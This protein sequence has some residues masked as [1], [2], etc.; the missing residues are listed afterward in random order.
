MTA[1]I[2]VVPV[3]LV[4]EL[5]SERPHLLVE[6]CG[7]GLVVHECDGA[8]LGDSEHQQARHRCRSGTERA[9][10]QV[11]VRDGEHAGLGDL[12]ENV[13]G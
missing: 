6:C 5:G 9:T 12:A 11:L 3:L 8:C 10:R 1:G 4:R 7:S 2:A 13:G